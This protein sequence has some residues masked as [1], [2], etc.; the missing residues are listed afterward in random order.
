MAKNINICSLRTAEEEDAKDKINSRMGLVLCSV[1]Q[2]R[3]LN[4]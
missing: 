1:L 2:H 3:I 4:I